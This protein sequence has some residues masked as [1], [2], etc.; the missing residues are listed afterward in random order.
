VLEGVDGKGLRP[1]IEALKKEADVA[2][3]VGIDGGKASVAVASSIPDRFNAATLVKAAVLAMG[4]QGGGGRP[5]FAQG[6]APDATRSAAAI[7][8]VRAAL[9]G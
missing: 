1:I 4:G 2:A 8:A 7:A 9:E 5:D 6:G 3:V